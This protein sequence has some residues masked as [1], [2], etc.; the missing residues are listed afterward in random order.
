MQILAI[1][2]GR[3]FIKLGFTHRQIV[4][5]VN[6]EMGIPKDKDKFS[7]GRLLGQF[8]KQTT[9]LSKTHQKK[10]TSQGSLGPNWMGISNSKLGSLHFSSALEMLKPELVPKGGLRSHETGDLVNDKNSYRISLPSCLQGL[11]KHTVRCSTK[12]L[13][14]LGTIRWV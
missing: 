9:V 2:L 1:A 11:V 7:P 14:C 4:L 6:G 3:C 12:I 5:R 10:I 8:F 13:F